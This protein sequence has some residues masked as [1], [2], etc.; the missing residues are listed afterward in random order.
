M[1]PLST[2]ETTRSLV[3]EDL[4]GWYRPESLILAAFRLDLVEPCRSGI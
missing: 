1:P 2:A 3:N 4:A